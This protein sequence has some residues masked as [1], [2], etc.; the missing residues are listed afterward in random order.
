MRK[1]PNR[2]VRG[3]PGKLAELQRRNEA[4]PLGGGQHED[5]AIWILG[6]AD[7]AAAGWQGGDL[8]TIG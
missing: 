4:G 1:S 2:E 5:R 7:R 3:L 6:V 8:D